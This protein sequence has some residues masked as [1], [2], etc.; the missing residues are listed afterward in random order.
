LF[1][2]F[3]YFPP[4]MLYLLLLVYSKYLVQTIFHHASQLSLTV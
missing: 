2:S 4:N 1:F 3:D